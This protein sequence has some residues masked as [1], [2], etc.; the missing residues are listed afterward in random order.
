LGM[1]EH[2]YESFCRRPQTHLGSESDFDGLGETVHALK[3]Q[4]ARFV[5]KLDLLA[6][7]TARR[8]DI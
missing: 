6:R 8:G 2:V 4:G 5:A 7:H 3:E 1:R